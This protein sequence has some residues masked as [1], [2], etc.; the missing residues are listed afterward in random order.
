M[1]IMDGCVTITSPF[2]HSTPPPPPASG[3]FILLILLL[4]ENILYSTVKVSA[5]IR[6]TLSENYKFGSM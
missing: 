4:I 1:I 3:R 5:R 6:E 2:W